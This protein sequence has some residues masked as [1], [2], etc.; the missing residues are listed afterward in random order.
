MDIWAAIICII[1][2]V[3]IVLTVMK[4]RGR[5]VMRIMADNYIHVWGIY[6]QQSLSGIVNMNVCETHSIAPPLYF[7][8][9]RRVPAEAGFPVDFRV[10][11]DY[12]LRI[13][14]IVDQLSDDLHG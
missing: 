4:T 6:C 8:I 2:S 14:R 12:P 5:V 3:P 7:R 9:P 1:V 11:V 13:L 10:V